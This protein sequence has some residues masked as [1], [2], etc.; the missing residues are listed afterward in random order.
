M[1]VTLTKIEYLNAAY[2]GF[3]R[4]YI[5]R[6]NGQTDR[7]GFQ[8]GRYDA[9]I[10]G[11][12]AE[13]VASLALDKSWRGTGTIGSDDISSKIQV[14]STDRANGRLIVHPDDDDKHRFVLVVGQ[15]PDFGVPGWIFG[16][17]AK[18]QEWWQDPTGNRPA[19]FVPQSALNPL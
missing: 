3:I 12:V 14:R 15:F 10:Q 5:A 8:G 2:A 6:M 18:R 16:R 17:D 11:S 13:F 1:I 4:Q 19:F 9:D 7:Y